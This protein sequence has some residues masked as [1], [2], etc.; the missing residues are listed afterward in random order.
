VLWYSVLQC[1]G[2]A[3]GEFV[4]DVTARGRGSLVLCERARACVCV[5][6][7][8]QNNSSLSR[9]SNENTAPQHQTSTIVRIFPGMA[10]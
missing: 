3:S 7:D 10:T 6:V 5:C 2:L 4:S 9:T 1:G 8:R